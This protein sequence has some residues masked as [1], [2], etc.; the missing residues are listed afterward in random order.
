MKFKLPKLLTFNLITLSGISVPLIS[1]SCSNDNHKKTEDY[2]DYIHDRSFSLLVKFI[3]DKQDSYYMWGTCWILNKC[4]K[5]INSYHYYA[6]TNLHV[7]YPAF[8]DQSLTILSYQY[9]DC[10]NEEWFSTNEYTE[11]GENDISVIDEYLTFSN[12]DE[13]E[14]TKKLNSIDFSILDVTFSNPKVD[15][16]T[17]LNRI[18]EFYKKNGNI[19]KFKNEV[20]DEITSAY[21]AGFPMQEKLGEYGTRY[22][23]KHFID[24][25]LKK[26][27]ENYYH[28]IDDNFE[29]RDISDNYVSQIS[30][31]NPFTLS[32]GSSGSMLINN[33][34][35]VLGIY[36]GGWTTP[37]KK[38][39]LPSFSIFHSTE[40]S[41]INQYIN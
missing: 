8:S 4:D 14:A 23:Y 20:E 11:F 5:D 29:L 2:F 34:Y 7:S 39:I 6:A 37:D 40:Y 16:K 33:Q 22:A 15:F 28:L 30:Y 25:Q 27:G 3:D 17:K 21:C 41:F 24:L 10:K 31:A 13:D 35:E 1:I 12:I 38:H 18:N 26:G 19:N 9:S 36:W 32:G